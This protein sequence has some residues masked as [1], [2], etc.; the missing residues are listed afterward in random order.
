MAKFEYWAIILIFA[1]ILLVIIAIWYETKYGKKGDPMPWFLWVLVGVA[2]I[3]IIIASILYA[4]DSIRYVPPHCVTLY[5]KECSKICRPVVRDPC[6][7]CEY[8]YDECDNYNEYDCESIKYKECL[9][10][11]RS[12]GPNSYPPDITAGLREDLYE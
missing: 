10:Y 4:M 7:P 9:I 6:D 11:E 12:N 5:E 2:I 3:L 8:D 1:V